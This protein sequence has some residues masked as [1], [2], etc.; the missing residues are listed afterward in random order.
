MLPFFPT[1]PVFTQEQLERISN[2]FD[3]AGQV[4]LG[5]V[6]VTPLVGGIDKLDIGGVI[7]GLVSV[8]LCWTV[9]IS[10]ARKKD[11]YTYD[12]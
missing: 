12:I 4:I 10:L 5:I 8:L 7:L 9:S 3:N 1:E 6:V 2:I 11:I